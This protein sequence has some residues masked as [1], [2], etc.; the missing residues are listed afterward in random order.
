MKNISNLHSYYVHVYILLNSLSTNHKIS[1]RACTYLVS[2]AGAGQRERRIFGTLR[3]SLDVCALIQQNLHHISVA[4][5]GCQDQRRET[6]K[7]ST[8]HSKSTPNQRGS[9]CQPCAPAQQAVLPLLNFQ[10]KYDFSPN[11]V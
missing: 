2:A 3:L 8:R 4:G 6:C 7:T 5:R 9:S 11:E 1:R 10:I